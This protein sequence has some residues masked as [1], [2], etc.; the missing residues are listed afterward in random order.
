VGRDDATGAGAESTDSAAPEI[1]LS[2]TQPPPADSQGHGFRDVFA[3]SANVVGGIERG[4]LAGAAFARDAERDL[5]PAWLRPG[6]GEHRWQMG[7]AVLTAIGLQLS[8]PAN[9]AIRPRLVLP[10]LEGVLLIA[11]MSA[12]PG[13]IT[14]RSAAIHTTA[15][16]LLGL[17]SLDNTVSAA[18]LVHLIIAGHA[19]DAAALLGHGAAIWATNVIV[20]ALWYWEFDRGGPVARAY[21][22]RRYPD[23]LF[24]QMAQA[25][26]ASP[27]WTPNFFD[28]LYTSF[29]N[30]TA[31]SPTDTL[32]LSRWCKAL[33][34]A[35]SAVSLITVALV[36]S[37]AVNIFK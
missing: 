32:P 4:L 3:A 35:Q 9:L 7:L 14:R 16:A 10:I 12:S 24:P 26:L 20:F 6:R 19:G 22:D 13:R 5:L 31:F 36:I 18:L 33:F 25:D 30:A 28:Y 15:L 27:D 37:R 8:L 1:A 17:V 21:A 11:L 23:L 34:L 2:G 29:T